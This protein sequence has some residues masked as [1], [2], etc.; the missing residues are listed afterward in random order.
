MPRI[1]ANYRPISLTTVPCRILER[2]ISDH[3]MNHLNANKLLSDDQF[4]FTP[5]KSTV[6]QLLCCLDDWSKAIEAGSPVD[7]VL[8][9]F[10]KAFDSVPHKKL[11]AKLSCFGIGGNIMQ[12]ITDFLT[13]R[14]QQVNLGL[15]LSPVTNVTSG[16]PQGSILFLI[17]IND[18]NTVSANV[19]KPLFAD[20]VKFYNMIK[21]LLDH[22]DLTSSLNSLE[23]WSNIW[24]LPISVSKCKIFH[25]GRNNMQLEYNL[26]GNPL[27]HVLEV[28]DL[29]VWFAND[30]KWASHCN[31]IVKSAWQRVAMIRRC[32]TSGD[33]KTLVWAFKVFVRPILEYASPVWSP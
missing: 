12:W 32:F 24:Q 11:C 14:S 6:L 22:S 21:T 26:N 25:I 3:L 2:V 17:Y 29:G 1:P 18:L 9:D 13:D 19:K 10:A 31:H 5:G 27:D 20:D 23:N 8:I 33:P 4:G 30:L 15:S 16:V 7:I 28:K